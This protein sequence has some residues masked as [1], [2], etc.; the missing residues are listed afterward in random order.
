[1]QLYALDE[2]Q[3]PISAQRAIKQQ[4]YSCPECSS[5]VRVRSGIHRQPHFYHLQNQEH[6][7]QN[8]KGMTHLQVQTYL[9]QHLPVGESRMEHRF[10]SIS[11]IADIVW[12]P[13][14]IV[15]EIQCSPISAEE[16]TNRCKDYKSLGYDVVWI[17][18]DRRFNQWRVSAAEMVL[19]S[20]PFYFTNMTAEGKGH[21]YDQYDIVHKGTRKKVLPPL[22]VDLSKRMSYQPITKNLPS[23]LVE[24]VKNRGWYFEGDLI[25]TWET[26]HPGDYLDRL[27]EAESLYREWMHPQQVPKGILSK[28]KFGLNRYIVHPYLVFFQILVEKATK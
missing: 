16:V 11:R 2:N 7:R 25:H 19:R 15:F 21:V 14:K 27:I 17:L 13:Q 10:P 18:H 1:M 28:I 9:L 8:G 20:F 23:S 24:R 3:Q 6:C 4:N 5:T 12:E 22:P 26:K